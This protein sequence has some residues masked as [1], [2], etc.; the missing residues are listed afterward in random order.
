MMAY[1]KRKKDEGKT[2]E[3]IEYH[4][5]ADTRTFHTEVQWYGGAEERG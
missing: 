1:L 4:T 2:A 3:E 5:I